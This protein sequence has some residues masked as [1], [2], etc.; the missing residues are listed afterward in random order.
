MTMKQLAL[1]AAAVL[2]AGCATTQPKPGSLTAAVAAVR[3]DLAP[4]AAQ[5]EAI[6]GQSKATPTAP[7]AAIPEGFERLEIYRYRDAVADPK[8][9]SR[10]IIYRKVESGAVVFDPP[11]DIPVSLPPTATVGADE[12][13]AAALADWLDELLKG[14]E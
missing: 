13:T 5:V 12:A 9:F 3:P 11:A 8:D 6:I 10:E 4:Y 2:L 7:V 14:R 1:I